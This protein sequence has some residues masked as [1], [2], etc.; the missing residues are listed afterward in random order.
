MNTALT[1]FL[2]EGCVQ[3]EVIITIPTICC[4]YSLTTTDLWGIIKFALMVK[5]GEGHRRSGPLEAVVATRIQLFGRHGG[6]QAEAALPIAIGMLRLL[7]EG[8]C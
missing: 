8:V 7:L 4:V 2:A 3:L 6:F 5:A 1:S